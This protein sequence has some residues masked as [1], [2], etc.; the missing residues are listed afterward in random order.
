MEFQKQFVA[1]YIRLQ[2]LEN[3]LVNISKK[4]KSLNSILAK[5]CSSPQN[6][7]NKADLY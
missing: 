4:I 2:K 6:S 7:L 1:F 3:F 5:K